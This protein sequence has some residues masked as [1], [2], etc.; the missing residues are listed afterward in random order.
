MVQIFWNE[1]EIY[2]TFNVGTEEINELKEKEHD[3]NYNKNK[4]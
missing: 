2:Q 3:S 4:H 1:E